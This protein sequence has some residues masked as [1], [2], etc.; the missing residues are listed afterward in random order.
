MSELADFFPFSVEFDPAGDFESLLKVVPAKWVVYLMSDEADR[1]VQL[2]CVRNLRYSLRRRLGQQ[3]HS[4]PDRRIDYRQIVRRI[5]WRKVYS[6]FE[7]DVVYLQAARMYFPETYRGMVGYQPAWFIHVDPDARF[8]RFTKTINLDARSGLLIGP[9][10]DKHAAA[11]LI[12]AL[13]DAFDLCRYHNILVQAPNATACAYKQMH[14]C[15]APC[16]GSITMEQYRQ[17]VR[18]SVRTLLQPDE[19]IEQNTQRM[20]QAAAALNFELAGKIRTYVETL[21]KLRQ[22]PFRHARLLR[23][24][25]Y[26]SIQAGP[27]ASTAKVFLILPGV[28]EEVAGLIDTPQDV[29]RLL[30][31]DVDRAVDSLDTTAAERVAVAAHH[32]FQPRS[33]P[34][35][36]IPLDLLDEKSIVK[37]FRDVQKQKKQSETEEAEGVVR[38]LQ[39]L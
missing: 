23:D 35:V 16:D 7:A 19:L 11:R 34:G 32:L 28:I 8:P 14:K 10:E 30:P 12:E 9:I 5:R 39:S 21:R 25:R 1:P 6:D 33:A 17:L 26:L 29:L 31:A 22:G 20:Q 38:E 18:W 36:F 27:Y 24:F 37:A 4:G 13:V 2:L 3:E 15:P